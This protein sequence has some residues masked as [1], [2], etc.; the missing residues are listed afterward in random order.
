MRKVPIFT[1]VVA[2]L[3]GLLG[4]TLGGAPAGA[5]VSPTWASTATRAERLV[6]ATD[7]GNAPAATPLR[8][9]VGLAIQHRT[10]LDAVI[11]RGDVLSR[12]DFAAHYAPSAAQTRAVASYL[13]S[14]GF[15]NVAVAANRLLV[16][17]DGT[18]AQAAQAFHTPIHHYLQRGA[19]V[20][21]NTQTAQVPS[22]L[23]STVVAVLGLNTAGAMHP[24]ATVAAAQNPPSEC[25]VPGAGY[26]CTY[27]PQGLWAAY[28][29]TSAPTGA[30]A[31]IAI[32]A[33]GDVSGVVTDLRTEE[34]ANRLHKVPVT[35]VPTGPATS[36][37]LG[38]D[39]WDMDTQ[40]STGMAA[41]VKHLYLYDA[42]TLNDS[43]IASEFN[44]FVSDNKAVAG[45]ASFGECEFQAFVDGSM[46][47]D[48]QAFAE[49]AAQGQTVFASSGDTGGFCP[50]GVGANGVPAGAPDVNYPA[51]SPWVVGVGGT[52][53]VTN[54]DDGSYDAEIAWAAGGGGPSLLETAPAWTSGIAPPVTVACSQLV[55][56]PCG[57]A[58][59]DIAM[60]ADPNSGANVYVGGE[61]EGV[62]GTSLS[63]PL[64]LGV[65]ARLQS[66]HGNALGF[67]GPELFAANGT[68]AF[69][70][71]V[72]GD[73]GPYPAAP[74]DDYATGIGTF[75]VAQAATLI[76]NS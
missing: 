19:D 73:T 72:L 7:L 39:E 29:A 2:A 38:L 9:A 14:Q 35:V 68:A 24:G 69:H 22:S 25:F 31:K 21:A 45:S 43:D 66:A 63:S 53:L 59:P 18:A 74:G 30:N 4:L 71:V 51:A 37:T 5:A 32:F 3:A 58:V 70:D 55:D 1:G 20:L 52:T 12:P 36:D 64:A 48:D 67:A 41:T 10:D 60:D 6:H 17:A 65:W 57:R 42:S 40:Y 75:D 27:N 33:E 28:D 15:T 46:L 34:T 49:A 62:G 76:T 44:R 23:A 26:P 61:P 13:S 50:V 8:I 56:V 54:T 16:T 11:A 47:V